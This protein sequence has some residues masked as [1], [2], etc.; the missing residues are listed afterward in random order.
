VFIDPVSASSKMHCPPVFETALANNSAFRNFVF[1][2]AFP[3]G[4]RFSGLPMLED[5]KLKANGFHFYIYWVRVPLKKKEGTPLQEFTF[6]G[7]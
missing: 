5:S 2:F 4:M 1:L 7:I 6:G 3:K